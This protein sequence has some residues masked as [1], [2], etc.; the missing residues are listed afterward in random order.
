MNSI[1]SMIRCVSPRPPGCFSRHAMRP[2]GSAA[3]AIERHGGARGVAQQ[4]LTPAHVPGADHHARMEVEARGLCHLCLRWS[5]PEARCVRRLARFDGPVVA[6]HPVASPRERGPSAPVE[7][8]VCSALSFVHRR[9]RERLRH[10]GNNTRHNGREVVSGRGAHRDEHRRAPV[11]QAAP[12][13][14]GGDD[15]KVHVEV[16]RTPEALNKGDRPHLHAHAVTR[17]HTA[18]R[19]V[20]APHLL[21]EHPRHH[22]EHRRIGRQAHPQREGDAQHP[23]TQRN[24]GQHAVDHVGRRWRGRRSSR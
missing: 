15:V 14:I 18:R 10:A 11:G 12:R 3:H 19:P 9:P 4:P 17:R 24:V 7:G 1:G 16:E 2:S 5:P 13:P 20:P 6:H 21:P 22:V 8:I 23:L